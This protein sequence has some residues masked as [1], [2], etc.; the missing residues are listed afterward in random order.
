MQARVSKC[1]VEVWLELGEPLVP[2]CVIG[3]KQDV[4]MSP[5]HVPALITA[6]NWPLVGWPQVGTT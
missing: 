1:Y 6:A 3:A 2:T 5:A 4:K